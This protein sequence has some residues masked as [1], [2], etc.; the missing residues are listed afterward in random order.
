M[1]K[2]FRTASSN[3]DFI[4]L[5]KSLDADLAI[6]D[7][8][9]HAFYSQFN[10]VDKIKFV[11]M[12]YE[13]SKQ[14][15]C[16]A[17]KAFAD[18]TMEVKRMFVLPESRNKGVASKVLSELE[19]WARELNCKTLVLETGKNQPEALNLYRKSGFHEIPNYGQYVGME[20][21]VCFEKEVNAF[22]F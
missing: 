4:E 1:I 15:G 13:N 16:G 22:N 19:R 12:A 9:D 7:G 8:A 3:P 2:I 18:Q 5:V 11:V 20:T 14:I 10:K 6:R 21:S 17:I